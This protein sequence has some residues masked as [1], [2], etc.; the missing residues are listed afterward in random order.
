MIQIIFG[1]FCIVFGATAAVMKREQM[2]Y[3]LLKGKSY[4]Y[5]E[6]LTY[7]NQFILVLR[8][9]SG[10]VAILGVYILIAGICSMILGV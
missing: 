10:L 5:E 4:R 8:I 7:L 9:L 1:L 6:K 3:I 2:I